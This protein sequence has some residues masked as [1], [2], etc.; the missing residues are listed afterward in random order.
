MSARRK[1]TGLWF[2]VLAGVWAP[3]VGA[4][5]GSL[6]II[7]D[8]DTPVPGLEGATFSNFGQLDGEAPDISG[9]NVVFACRNGRP[10]LGAICAY[11]NGEL[12]AIAESGVTLVPGSTETFGSSHLLDRAGPV[13]LECGDLR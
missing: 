8:T 9:R 2:G 3:A 6:R 7:A 5:E 1:L 13:P 11:I 10:G 12:R 4:Q